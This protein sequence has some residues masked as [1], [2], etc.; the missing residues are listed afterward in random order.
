M[1][2][3]RALFFIAFASAMLPVTYSR[4]VAAEQ[5]PMLTL[6]FLIDEAKPP[7]LGACYREVHSKDGVQTGY[8]LEQCKLPI[9]SNESQETETKSFYSVWEGASSAQIGRISPVE[10]DPRTVI[11]ERISVKTVRTAR[12]TDAVAMWTAC[13][14]LPDPSRVVVVTR[15]YA[16]PSKRTRLKAKQENNVTISTLQ[17]GSP[18]ALTSASVDRGKNG[19]TVLLE[20]TEATT[21]CNNAAHDALA[22]LQSQVAD[23]TKKAQSKDVDI[24]KK[25]EE[26]KQTSTRLDDAKI[27]ADNTMK[28]LSEQH[29]TTIEALT[30]LYKEQNDKLTEQ[31]ILLSGKVGSLEAA[32][33]A[34][35][36]ATL[37]SET[38]QEKQPESR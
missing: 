37:A 15:S 13:R 29:R 3:F 12:I 7:S 4:I 18:P 17:F 16:G 28:A 10:Q 20:V 8:K 30:R 27:N 36:S 32:L 2:R 34:S 11:W 26:I 33:A 19:N 24:A 9:E 5:T 38:K 22:A 14:M 21:L 35:K 1:R 25:E 6:A 23:L 31:V